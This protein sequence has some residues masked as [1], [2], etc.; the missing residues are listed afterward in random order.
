M[1]KTD[2]GIYKES[3]SKHFLFLHDVYLHL[4]CESF[5]F[6]YLDWFYMWLAKSANHNNIKTM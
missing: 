2:N 4:S 3:K 6:V 1:R 5:K